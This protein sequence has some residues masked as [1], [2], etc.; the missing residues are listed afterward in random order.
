MFEAHGSDYFRFNFEVLVVNRYLWNFTQLSQI[1]WIWNVDFIQILLANCKV[2]KNELTCKLNGCHGGSKLA[3]SI[4][5]GFACNSI[6][7]CARFVIVLSFIFKKPIHITVSKWAVAMASVF[8]EKAA[9]IDNGRAWQ[10]S[11]DLIFSRYKKNIELCW[12]KKW[13]FDS[14]KNQPG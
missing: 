11:S 8:R 6:E 2:T 10:L 14:Q 1:T 4:L 13:R 12:M 9:N 7:F 3:T 5:C